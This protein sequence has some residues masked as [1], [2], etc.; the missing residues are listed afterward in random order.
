MSNSLNPDTFP[1]EWEIKPSAIEEQQFRFRR[2]HIQA[3][4]GMPLEALAEGGCWRRISD[5]LTRFD[6]V[7][8]VA[9][10]AS[11]WASLLVLESG[12]NSAILKPL[13]TVRFP[14]EAQDADDIPAH[15]SIYWQGDKTRGGYKIKNNQT[16]QVLPGTFASR[17]AARI[18][19]CEA[20]PHHMNGAAA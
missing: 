13:N 5:K 8:I 4:I 6:H 14:R 1:P 18:A 9:A 3:P 10:D 2:W 20:F 16:G 19:A 15:L 11:W 7:E 17:A 12:P